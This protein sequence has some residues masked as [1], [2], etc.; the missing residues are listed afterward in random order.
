MGLGLSLETMG[1]NTIEIN[2]VFIK[3]PASILRSSTCVSQYDTR[4]MTC[5]AYLWYADFLELYQG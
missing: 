2:L 3:N 4:N 5:P 1:F